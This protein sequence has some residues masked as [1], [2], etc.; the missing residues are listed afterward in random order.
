MIH[1]EGTISILISFIIS[2]V[3]IL[4]SSYYLTG[5]LKLFLI[6]LA[7]IFFII[8]VQFFRNPKRKIPVK[9]EKIV[10]APADGKIVVIE[11]YFEKEFFNE[12]KKLVSIFMSPLNVHVNRA[13]ISGKIVYDKY[14]NGKY[15]AA[16]NPKSSEENERTTIVIENNHGT[17]LLRQ[18][19]GALAKRICKY[20]K[21]GDQVVQGQDYG[22]IKFGS[23]VDIYLPLNAQIKV[24]IDDKV[25][26]NL[27]EI[28]SL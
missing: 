11:E 19:A 20:V 6:L 1:K 12:K 22:F 17:I 14:H 16:W 5:F 2:A 9:N 13:P 26:G 18:V 10:Y 24:K 23:R 27:H 25:K 28:A 3:I 7:I 4:I 8:I 15:L 21:T